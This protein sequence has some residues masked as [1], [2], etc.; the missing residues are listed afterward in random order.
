MKLTSQ[1][2]LYNIEV[3]D[4]TG[5]IHESFNTIGDGEFDLSKLHVGC[6]LF[7]IKSNN[8]IVK[9]MCWIKN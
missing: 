8:E 2:T 5:K 4:L 3:M 9:S 7:N 6:Y 1:K